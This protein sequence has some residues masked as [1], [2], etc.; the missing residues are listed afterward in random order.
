MASKLPAIGVQAVVQDFDRYLVQLS[1]IEQVTNG[2]A[3]AIEKSAAS[4][5]KAASA[6][7]SATKSFNPLEKILSKL[8]SQFGG[9]GSKIQSFANEV[10]IGGDKVAAFA[11]SLG[12]STTALLAIAAAATVA[13]G[14][15]IALGQRGAGLVGIAESF[16][17]LT[18]AAG[19]DAV[20]ALERLRVA[21]AGTISDFELL[22][23]TNVALAGATGQFAQEFGENLPRLLE[24]ARVQSRATGQDTQFLFQS[25]VSGIKRASPMLIDNTGLVLKL[26]EA[27]EAMALS[28]GV[29][30]EQLTSEQKQL[31]I[32]NATL[33]AGQVAIEGFAGIQETAADK[34]ARMNAT[35]TNIGDILAVGV[36]PAFGMFLDVINRVLGMVQLL[37]T[38][39]NPLISS[40]LEAGAAIITGPLQGILSLLEPV[41]RLTSFFLTL[42][43][44]I[45]QPVMRAIGALG[46][47]FGTG[48][49]RIVQFLG[50][51][52]SQ[53]LGLN[54]DNLAL[55]LGRGAGFVFGAFAEGIMQ[56]ANNVILPAV[57]W[58]AETIANF[59]M[60]ESPPKMGPLSQIDKGG[61]NTMLAWLEGFGSVSLEPVAQV[62]ANVNAALG[63][64]GA[65]SL[66]QVEA[67]LSVLDQALAP[68]N[69]QLEI[70]KANFEAIST[71]AKAAL[72]AID[73]QVAAAQEALAAGDAG[74]A[75]RIR[76]F[77]AQ[78][79]MIQDVLDT[80]QQLVDQAQIQQALAKAQ[81]A[82]E[83]ALLAIQQ[84]RLKALETPATKEAKEAA[85][86]AG[87]GAGAGAAAT[88]E[89]A[90]G[91]GGMGGF[92]LPS[93][94]DL[95]SGQS[96]VDQ[97]GADLGQGFTE[98]LAVSMNA[99]TVDTFNGLVSQIG[100]QTARIGQANIG[101]RIADAFGGLGT[102]I[103]EKLTEA[104]ATITDWIGGITDPNREGSIP[105]SF[106][107]LINGDWDALTTSLTA[108]FTNIANDIAAIDWEGVLGEVETQFTD[109]FTDVS[110][111]FSDF[112]T[113]LNDPN[114]MEG[115]LGA[116][117]NLN[118]QMP[119][120]LQ[121]LG[122][123]FIDWFSGN[124]ADA[125]TWLSNL[126]DPENIDSIPGAL[127]LLPTRVGNALRALP[128]QFNTSILTPI[129]DTISG[130]AENVRH[131]FQDT[132][133]G[134]LKG[135]IDA[136][137]AW[138]TALPQRIF[139]ALSNMGAVFYSVLAGP[140][141]A[142]VNA[143]LGAI[144]SLANSA[145]QG[146][147]TLMN[148][149]QGIA[150]AVG[151]G[152]QF[153][154][155]MAALNTGV[156]FPRLA[157]P[158]APAPTFPG[159]ASGG[160]FTG[161]RLRVGE[162]GAEIM[163][164]AASKTAVFPKKDSR[165][166]ETIASSVLGQGGSMALPM[167]AGAGAGNSS[168]T[169]Y[170]QS[171]NMGTPPSAGNSVQQIATLMSMRRT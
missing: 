42:A 52:V 9:V 163:T 120:F 49:T 33:A 112:A 108:P 18:Q 36:Q 63:S 161:G 102:L 84:A 93:V 4:T 118:S 171:F 139:D 149:L 35:L 46:N 53:N 165:N 21:S 124:A 60:G 160:I 144:E 78:R 66:P 79:E 99:G 82:P 61:A 121:P 98:G 104:S 134:T 10:G 111:L 37:V 109:W 100:T 168:N 94:S 15:F 13:I 127:A 26:G 88:P 156:V 135:F 44:V 32:L 136:G 45:L 14:V 43:T 70:I 81:Q 116:L 19:F 131:F 17:R 74:A 164:N 25:L 69:N 128:D 146:L 12:I 1:K 167:L 39:L 71:P 73:R 166:L 51:W 3:R 138:F 122:Q 58:I 113:N 24:L 41:V 80:Q 5:Q 67:R 151:L 123:Q 101:Q 16:D 132:G 91:A 97:M 140:V 150:D 50:D 40:F 30:V 55:N 145:L 162:R 86:A 114:Y 8:D 64:I 153:A 92:G 54:F 142:G 62:A 147:V 96:A 137:V 155:I 29:T 68:F 110:T 170:N 2:A 72:D 152:Q 77:D 141:V 106:N 119:A 126:T 83:R 20:A 11:S 130:V 23:I 75:A 103:Q 158:T 90:G 157:A 57:L 115:V 28:L 125:A 7:A 117:T 89:A 56:A 95:I 48:V 87:S 107:A 143:V 105:Y 34:L 133:E 65:L 85:Q 76:T 159:A 27:N 169:T 148:G 129:Q 31:A 154:D 22:R 59:L 38:A 6:A 47:A